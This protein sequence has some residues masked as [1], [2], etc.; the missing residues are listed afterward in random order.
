MGLL[1]LALL[2][3]AAGAITAVV[4]PLFAIACDSCR[5]GVRPARFTGALIGAAPYA[6]LLLSLGT[7]IAMFARRDGVRVAL[8][9]LGALAALLFTMVFLGQAGA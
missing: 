6:S 7:V 2:V 3:L 1:L 9:G 5:D 8:I 4:G